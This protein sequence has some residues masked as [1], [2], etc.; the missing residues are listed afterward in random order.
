VIERISIETTDLWQYC[1]EGV[2]AVVA[3]AGNAFVVGACT[4]REGQTFELGRTADGKALATL[5]RKA[6]KT[7]LSRAQPVSY[8]ARHHDPRHDDIPGR[9]RMARE[10]DAD[11]SA[12]SPR[13][14]RVQ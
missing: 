14:A 8:A 13:R 3:R 10:P 1:D 2:T 9:P 4:Q 5:S 12:Q 7:V 11:H 6:D